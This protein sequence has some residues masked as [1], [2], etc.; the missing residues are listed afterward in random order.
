[1]EFCIE[2][3][4]GF[5]FYHYYDIIICIMYSNL[6]TGIPEKLM[7]SAFDLFDKIKTENSETIE[8][9]V[10]LLFST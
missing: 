3:K 2:Y 6:L 7:D 10:D 5:N 8:Y 9:R 1:M 4:N